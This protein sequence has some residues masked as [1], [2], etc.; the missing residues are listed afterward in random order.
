MFT[1]ISVGGCYRRGLKV[2]S[3]GQ[4]ASGAAASEG[5]THL[6]AAG[7]LSTALVATAAPRAAAY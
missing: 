7:T 2:A 6:M 4:D 3:C 5:L 1:S